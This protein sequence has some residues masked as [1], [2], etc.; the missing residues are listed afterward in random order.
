VSNFPEPPKFEP[1]KPE[2]PRADITRDY[3]WREDR[4]FLVREDGTEIEF[5]QKEFTAL[6]TAFIN[7]LDVV[8]LRAE[9]DCLQHD[10]DELRSNALWAHGTQ[11]GAL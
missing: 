10:L 2:V 1:R 3:A 8:S 5:T 7:M 4:L 11:Q 9:R 6:R